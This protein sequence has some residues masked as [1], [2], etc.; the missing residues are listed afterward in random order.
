MRGRARCA[1]LSGVCA[2]RDSYLSLHGGSSNAFTS[3]EDTCYYFSINQA[4]ASPLASSLAVVARIVVVARKDTL[5][6]V[7]SEARPGG[8]GG[9]AARGLTARGARRTRWNRRWTASRAFS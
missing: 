7:R 9:A 8:S 2:A 3:N 6:H 5:S 1:G 4:R